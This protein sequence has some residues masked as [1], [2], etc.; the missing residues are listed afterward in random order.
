[1]T[2]TL[3]RGCHFTAT[4]IDALTQATKQNWEEESVKRFES[5]TGR[6]YNGL[7]KLQIL[8]AGYVFNGKKE[9]GEWMLEQTGWMHDAGILNVSPLKAARYQRSFC[10]FEFSA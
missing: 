7:N 10:P 4:V 3:V 2:I 5:R 9:L 8:C 1:M 6:K